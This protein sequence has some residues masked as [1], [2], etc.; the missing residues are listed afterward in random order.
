MGLGM[1]LSDDQIKAL[2]TSEPKAKGPTTEPR[3]IDVF[4]KLDHLMIDS[5]CENPNC[6]DP[7]DH[8]D[9]GRKIVVNIPQALGNDTRICRF[10]FLEGY[11]SN[12]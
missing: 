9:L 1:N 2:L 5:G 7:R 12:A 6:A 3:T 10:C 11:L 4:Y 8:G